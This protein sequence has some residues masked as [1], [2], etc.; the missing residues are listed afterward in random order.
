LALKSVTESRHQRSR[1]SKKPR[2]SAGAG[3]D[4]TLGGAGCGGSSCGELC[5][6]DCCGT[7]GVAGAALVG[8][9]AGGELLCASAIPQAQAN[10]S[11]SKAPQAQS[12]FLRTDLLVLLSGVTATPPGLAPDMAYSRPHCERSS[13]HTG[14][15]RGNLA[16]KL[17]VNKVKAAASGH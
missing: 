5:A 9:D 1:L 15:Q 11:A 17:G 13:G 2:F 16:A 10:D 4:A 12:R 7:A 6:S 3:L 14:S 8:A